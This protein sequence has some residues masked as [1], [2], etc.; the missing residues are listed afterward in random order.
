M[1]RNGRRIALGLVAIV[2][3]A[4]FLMKVIPPETDV[5]VNDPHLINIDGS[6]VTNP[7]DINELAHVALNPAF[8]FSS[9]NEQPAR[10]NNNSG[11]TD[12]SLAGGQGPLTRA[13]APTPGGH[14]STPGE[15][16][17]PKDE[18]QPSPT[19]LPGSD[20]P[21][22]PTKPGDAL[23]T[24]IVDNDSRSDSPTTPG[25]GTPTPESPT[26]P[27]IPDPT[28]PDP[29]NPAPTNPGPIDP[30]PII[31][32]PSLPSLPPG[33]TPVPGLDENPLHDSPNNEPIPGDTSKGHD[34]PTQSVPDQGTTVIM[35][36]GAVALL[37]AFSR[38]SR[39]NKTA[40]DCS[41]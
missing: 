18:H 39:T 8:A 4:G 16:S 23:F 7:L 12:N 3:G 27:T 32:V 20:L 28:N 14:F 34:Y 13:L 29:T 36:G 38:R 22:A 35:I 6:L 1:N 31:D 33:S 19:D 9:P 24:P 41:Q 25:T 26:P 11:Q 2:L 37:L 5:G 21:L 15:G 10:Q 17:G 40:P 30:P